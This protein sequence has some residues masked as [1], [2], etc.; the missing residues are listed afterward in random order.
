M[1]VAIFAIGGPILLML[2]L[3]HQELVRMNNR[4]DTPLG[5]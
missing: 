5:G 4:N 2:V 1:I 3:I